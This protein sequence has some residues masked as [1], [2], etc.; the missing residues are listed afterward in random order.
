VPVWN[1]NLQQHGY[2]GE[3]QRVFPRQSSDHQAERFA[4]RREIRCDVDRVC[5]N[6]E[7]NDHGHKPSRADILG[8]CDDVL[9][10]DAADLGADQLDGDH[11]WRG[12]KHGPEQAVAERSAGLGVGRNAGRIVVGRA[13]HQTRSKQTLD[14]VDRG[15]HTDIAVAVCERTSAKGSVA[16]AVTAQGPRA[17]AIKSPA[18]GRAFAPFWGP[19]CAMCSLDRLM[20]ICWNALTIWFAEVSRKNLLESVAQVCSRLEV[21]S[22][23]VLTWMV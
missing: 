18:R 15:L 12:E 11:E 21:G 2:R 20:P 6:Q 16:H 23:P 4:H 1:E 19:Y 22:P 10:G 9:A 14:G 17:A 8:V 5:C 13:G 3:D 7:N